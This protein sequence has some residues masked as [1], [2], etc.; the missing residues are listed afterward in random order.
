MY[1]YTH[2]TC[3]ARL[4]WQH[5]GQVAILSGRPSWWPQTG[6]ETRMQRTWFV[7]VQLRRAQ[8]T[9]K[10]SWW[11]SN[12]SSQLRGAWKLST[13]L[14]QLGC[15]AGDVVGHC[16]YSCDKCEVYHDCHGWWRWRR[17]RHRLGSLSVQAHGWW[18]WDHQCGHGKS[19]L[20]RTAES[21]C[22]FHHARDILVHGWVV[23][24]HWGP[25]A[26][27]AEATHLHFAVQLPIFCG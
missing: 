20:S 1:I 24:V 14:S 21:R 11:L 9:S 23:A 8:R 2:I 16:Q 13:W 17:F 12:P 27:P 7:Q 15:P 22:H 18:V 19:H 25:L 6:L 26:T 10:F 4:L 5:L 3:Y